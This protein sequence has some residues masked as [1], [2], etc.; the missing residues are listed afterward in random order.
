MRTESA[1]GTTPAPAVPP[2]VDEGYPRRLLITVLLA[3]IGFSASMTIVSASLADLAA[4]LGTS[5]ST[6]SWAVTGLFLT[7]AV[8]TPVM[9]KLGDLYG[10]RRVFLAGSAL[11]SL[12]TI[13]CGLSWDASSFIG[14]RMVVGVGIA[15]TM[16][17]GMAL[18]MEAYPVSE[19][20]RAMGWFQMAMTGAPVLGLVIGGPMIEAWGWRTVFAV[21]APITV[22]GLV[23][24]WRVVV[25]DGRRQQVS[26]DWGGA[27]TLGLSILSFLL[28]L[29]AVKSQGPAS[30]LPLVLFVAAAALLAAF[31]RI[32]GT[33]PAPLL[34]LRYLR[35]RNFTGPLL[36][37]ALGQF[38][39][40]GGFLVTPI[41]LGD[42]FGLSVGAIAFMLLFRPGA[43]TLASPVGGRLTATLG[44]RRVIIAGSVL[45]VASMLAFAA[46]AFVDQLAVVV[47]GLVLSGLAMGFAS[48]AYVT[49]IADAVDRAD[50]G[51]ANGTSA[52]TMNIGMLTGI[53]AMFVILGDDPSTTRFGW[54][55]VFGAAVAAVGIIGG[56]L[57]RDDA[58]AA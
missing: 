46:S 31:A 33:H 26:I 38:A 58:H 7:M 51:V 45:M 18:V 8:G 5:E 16:P 47:L 1:T 22:I 30:V 40:M 50:L 55:F 36:A 28:G 41:F 6:M 49:V 9:G 52:T 54:V 35:R 25:D 27:A 44:G 15:A 39:Y 23:G 20:S 14:F 32:E 11:L 43:S 34:P 57:V 17:N 42:A 2:E 53:Q 37:Q 13:G 56:L 12:A 29:E 24:A 3:I 4:A 48:P 19:R 21:L 10:H